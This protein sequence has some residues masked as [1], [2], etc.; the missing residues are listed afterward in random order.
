MIAKPKLKNFKIVEIYN[1]RLLKRVALDLR[2]LYVRNSRY[3][4]VLQP[5]DLPVPQNNSDVI[6]LKPNFYLFENRWIQCDDPVDYAAIQSKIKRIDLNLLSLRRV[7]ICELQYD[8]PVRT[9]IDLVTFLSSHTRLEVL[10]VHQLNLEE[11]TKTS[12]VFLFLQ[13]LSI[14][15]I[16]V[17]DGTTQDDAQNERAIFCMHAPQLIYLQTG[18]YFDWFERLVVI[19][20][21]ST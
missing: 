9:E 6:L 11:D 10:E 18:G 7:K 13:I 12:L 17:V 19:D 2:Q 3:A 20:S 4:T 16:R 5:T 14:G 15:A 1:H 8:L 21:F